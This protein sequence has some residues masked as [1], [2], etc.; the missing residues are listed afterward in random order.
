MKPKG[1]YM[2]KP[3][4]AVAAVVDGEDTWLV[5]RD[6]VSHLMFSIARRGP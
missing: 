5:L 1:S 6:P 4:N 3:S 2:Q